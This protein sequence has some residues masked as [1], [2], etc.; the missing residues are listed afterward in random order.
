MTVI[1]TASNPRFS[2]SRLDIDR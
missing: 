1:A 2:V